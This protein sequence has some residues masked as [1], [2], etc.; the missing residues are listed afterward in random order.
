MSAEQVTGDII[1][2]DGSLW[3]SSSLRVCL[4]R[5]FG[6]DRPPGG[7]RG[8]LVH[9]RVRVRAPPGGCAHRK[10][11]LLRKGNV[12]NNE[13]LNMEAALERGQERPHANSPS[14]AAAAAMTRALRARVTIQMRVYLISI[15]AEHS[16][17]P[18][19]TLKHS[20]KQRS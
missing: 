6:S 8:A 20:Y 10:S 3:R 12:E 11:L 1:C 18:L 15:D 2:V 16:N 9:A 4:C 13:K 14:T 7:G 5:S 19:T 17:T